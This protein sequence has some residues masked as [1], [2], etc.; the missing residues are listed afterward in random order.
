MKEALISMTHK[1]LTR[2]EIIQKVKDKRLT[3]FTASEHLGLSLRQIKQLCCRFQKEGPKGLISRKRQAIGNH[4]LPPELKQKVVELI[5]SKYPDFGPTLAQEK[6]LELDHIHLSI[7][8]IRNLMIQNG[9]WEIAKIKRKTVHQMRERRTKFG[10]LIQIDGSPHDWFEGRAPKCTLIVFIDDATGKLLYLQFGKAETTWAY[11]DGVKRTVL[12]EGIP[13]AYYSDKHGIF[14]V[15]RSG[16]LSGDGLTQFGRIVKDLGIKS[17]CAN[18][19]QAK[20]RVERANRIL[21]DRLVKELRLNSIS[22]IE[23]A[24]AFI[25]S[26]IDKYNQRFAKTP[27]SMLN[28]H[29]ELPE[30]WDLARI[31][32]LRE[33][34]YLSKNLIFQYKNTLYQIKTQRPTYA[35]RK[36]RVDVLENR[37]GDVLV[38][39]K[40]KS[41]L[42]TTFEERPIEAEVVGAKELNLKL[43]T[44]IKTRYKPSKNHPWKRGYPSMVVNL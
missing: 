16:A 1:E 14:K 30:N 25:P 36:A 19:P 29:K 8:S 7:G 34:R 28:A 20:G 3:Q 10:E 44:L 32:R 40:N 15:N 23:E 21:Q 2:L 11:L 22:T 33:T 18:S 43:D 6:L 31:F 9:I 35:L 27:K 41:L 5:W 39:Y 4:R 12:K 38:E 17:I 24:N 42:Y 37:E 13:L 26:F